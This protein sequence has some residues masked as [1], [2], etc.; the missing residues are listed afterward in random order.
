MKLDSGNITDDLQRWVVAYMQEITNKNLSGRTR[1][2]YAGIL[3]DFVEHSRQFQGELGIED[4][5]RIFLNGYLAERGN[6]GRRFSATTKKLHITVLKTFF[7]YITENNDNNH[8]F[9]KMFKKMNIKSESN[10]KPALNEDDVQ[11]LLNYLEKIKRARRNQ[12]TNI[13][14]T[15]LCKIMLFGGLR[16]VELTHLRLKD[17]VYDKEDDIYSLLIEGKGGKQRTVYIPRTLI[18]DEVETLKE[19]YGEEWLICSTRN[20]TIVDRTNLYQIITGIY[21]RA[22]VDHTGLHILRHTFARRLVNNNTNLET[23]RDLLG[24]SNIA[25]TAKFYAKTNENNKKAA[26]SRLMKEE[27]EGE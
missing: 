9:E 11:R 13:R 6:T 26:I 18:E 5:N 4:I 12:N 1:D 23:I 17:M 22:G 25:I 21:K 8:D 27:N 7:L 16:A 20:G 19:E 3:D 24:H 14:N 15:L 10:E 2:I